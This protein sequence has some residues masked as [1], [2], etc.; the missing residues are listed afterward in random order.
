MLVGERISGSYRSLLNFPK[1]VDAGTGRVPHWSLIAV[2]ME[3]TF[4][5]QKYRP[6][7]IAIIKCAAKSEKRDRQ[8]GKTG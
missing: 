6:S 3:K 2:T 4:I 7:K 8:C 1:K 5:H